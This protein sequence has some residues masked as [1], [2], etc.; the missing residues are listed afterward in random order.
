MWVHIN[1]IR[2]LWR[3]YPPNTHNDVHVRA[4]FSTLRERKRL[5]DPTQSE[6]LYETREKNTH[7]GH[8]KTAHMEWLV[9]LSAR[10]LDLDMVL[11]PSAVPICRLFSPKP[12]PRELA[13]VIQVRKVRIGLAPERCE[14]RDNVA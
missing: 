2:R 4:E 9:L 3:P 5:L 10:R 13:L 6:P 12:R 14:A 1:L 11:W 8:L 7:R